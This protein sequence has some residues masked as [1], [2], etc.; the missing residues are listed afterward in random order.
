M[1]IKIPILLAV[2]YLWIHTQN[3]ILAASAWGIAI[4]LFGLII[5]GF[6]FALVLGALISF[7]ICFGIFA[8]MDYLEGSGFQW[9]VGLVGIGVL[10]L[11]G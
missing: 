5:N 10:V 8:L 1:L 2:G 7:F 4:F 3:S 6:S 11:I 9:L